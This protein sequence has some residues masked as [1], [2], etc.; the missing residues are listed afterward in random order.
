MLTPDVRFEG[1]STESWRRLVQ[2]FAPRAAPDVEPTR[3]RGL[4]VALH[5]GGRLRKLLHTHTGRLDPRVAWPVP[6]EELARTYHASWALAAH[7][8]ALE[9]VMERFGARV[10]RHDDLTAQG[11]HL[12]SVVRELSA[13]GQI[14]RWPRRLHNV[15]Q[16]TDAMVR[17]SLDGVVADGRCVLLGIFRDGELWTSLV[18]R[19]RGTSVDVIAGPDEIRGAMGLLSGDWRRDYRHLARVVEATY[20]ELGFGCFAEQERFRE[21]LVDPRPGAWSRAA[22][23]RD[24]V[25]SPMPAAVGLAVGVDG[26]RFALDGLRAVTGRIEAFRRVEPFVTRARERLG[27]ALGERDVSATLGFDPLEA[28]RALLRR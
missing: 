23:V 1:F 17:R 21:L 2:L 26:A 12:V 22:A 28:L 16:P 15:P 27:E 9:E 18:L 13:E 25:I 19:R 20:G 5:D 7:V 10:R 3:P 4:V 6:L 11:L 24:V 8:G 14:E